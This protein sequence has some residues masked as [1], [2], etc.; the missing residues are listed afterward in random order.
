MPFQEWNE[1]QIENST[2]NAP[3]TANRMKNGETAAYC[4]SA[5]RYLFGG[6]DGSGSLVVLIGGGDERIARRAARRN[7]R[8]TANGREQADAR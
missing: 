3:N 1:I 6:L 2:G 7:A 5:W 4:G 8:Q